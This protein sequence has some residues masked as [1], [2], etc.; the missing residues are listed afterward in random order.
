[1]KQGLHHEQGE[2][3]MEGL[4]LPLLDF[5]SCGAWVSQTTKQPDLCLNNSKENKYSLSSHCEAGTPQAL[6]V[7]ISFHPLNNPVRGYYLYSID[8]ETE[9]QGGECVCSEIKD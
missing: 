2:E 7:H 1:M 3:G 5:S 4:A 9:T 8:E 6:S